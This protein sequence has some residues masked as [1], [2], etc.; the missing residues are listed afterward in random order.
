[1]L[2]ESGISIGSDQT[3]S[4]KWVSFVF[5]DKILGNALRLCCLFPDTPRCLLFLLQERRDFLFRKRDTTWCLS[6]FKQCILQHCLQYGI[7]Y[8]IHV[9][10]K[11]VH[12]E[13]KK[14]YVVI[15]AMG[16]FWNKWEK[17][18][19]SG[20]RF[21]QQISLVFL[22]KINAI[23]TKLYHLFSKKWVEFSLLGWPP[24]L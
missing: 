22:I 15:H 23:K 13:Q 11:W 8:F 10:F 18:L 17:V 21:D 6:L 2:E 4:I 1:M 9:H 7:T 12:F 19:F 24:C 3:D 20:E 14:I 5:T 16:Q